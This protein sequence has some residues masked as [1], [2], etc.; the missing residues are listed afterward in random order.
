[1]Q[2]YQSLPQLYYAVALFPARYWQICKSGQGKTLSKKRGCPTFAD[3]LFSFLNDNHL[4]EP[5]NEK[6]KPAR[7][8]IIPEEPDFA[9]FL[10]LTPRSRP[11]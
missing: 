4:P 2:S 9:E 5:P 6:L 1:M 11:F 7:K 10:K 8:T 3:N